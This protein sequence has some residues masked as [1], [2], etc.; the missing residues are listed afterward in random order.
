MVRRANRRWPP[1][2]R[3]VS[4]DGVRLHVI[5]RGPT[6]Q[7]ARKPPVV[8]IHGSNGFVQDWT[9]SIL[10]RVAKNEQ[11]RTVALDRA[12]SGHSGRP[13]TQLDPAVHLQ[14]IRGALRELSLERPVVV[15]HS[16]GGPVVLRWAVEHPEELAGVVHVAGVAFGAEPPPRLPIRLRLRVALYAWTFPLLLPYA[17]RYTLQTLVPAFAP[18]PVARDYLRAAQDLWTRPTQFRAAIE[19]QV[20]TTRGL[21]GLARQYGEITVPLA[22]VASY[23]DRHVLR[24]VHADRLATVVPGA[25]LI[26][27]SPFGHDI[28]HVHP[29]PVLEAIRWVVEQADR[30]A[31]DQRSADQPLSVDRPGRTA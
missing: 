13:G 25:R 14:L 15:G 1:E 29:E 19:D 17:R 20:F 5:E 2:G 12:G 7:S 8:L 18:E 11:H 9:M 31:V 16:F 10:D 28:P 26:D 6:R 22:I 27:A 30:V 23:G 24:K 4:V 3:F 21:S